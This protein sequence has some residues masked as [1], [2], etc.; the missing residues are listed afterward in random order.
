MS[1]SRFWDSRACPAAG[2]PTNALVTQADNVF[3]EPNPQMLMGLFYHSVVK[4]VA[5]GIE[6]GV[7]K[8][9]SMS[10]E[11]PKVVQKY[12]EKYP[13]LNLDYDPFVQRIY[14]TVGNNIEFG[15]NDD[16]DHAS[17]G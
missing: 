7:S 9:E 10:K 17:G 14:D 4:A 12:K 3:S 11:F 6:Q 8:E 16:R 5:R 15:G 2:L 1:F 13:S